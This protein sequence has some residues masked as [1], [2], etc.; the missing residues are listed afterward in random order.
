MVLK[1]IVGYLVAALLL[2]SGGPGIALATFHAKHSAQGHG[3][4]ACCHTRTACTCNMRGQAKASGCS[5]QNA[6]CE[7]RPATPVAFVL[8][9][10]VPER[11]VTL[12]AA[13]TSEAAALAARDLPLTG[14][15]ELSSPPPRFLA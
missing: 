8:G 4:H 11:S 2:W 13:S 5:M 1:Q 9:P 14:S 12:H 10:F 6:P 7:S 3:T 15:L